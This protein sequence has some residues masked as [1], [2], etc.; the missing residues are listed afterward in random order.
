MKK[1]T[2]LILV[3]SIMLSMMFTVVVFAQNRD[4]E[5]L[6]TDIVGESINEEALAKIENAVNAINKITLNS[7]F[8]EA[9]E[10]FNLYYYALS[11]VN[12]DETDFDAEK[13]AEFMNIYET[14]R[15]KTDVSGKIAITHTKGQQPVIDVEVNNLAELANKPYVVIV[16]YYDDEGNYMGAHIENKLSS[17]ANKEVF[18]ITGKNCPASASKVKGFI[19][20]SFSTLIPLADASE[21]GN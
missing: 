18:T 3:L 19:W 12:I 11:D 2:A 10:A 6:I 15:A 9:K 20:K 14:L 5:V 21:T 1:L 4:Y 17:A 13:I 16:A 7:S 8:K